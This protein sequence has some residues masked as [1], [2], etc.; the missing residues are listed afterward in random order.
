MYVHA[1]CVID[2]ASPEHHRE[3]LLNV[4]LRLTRS[5]SVQ[6]SVEIRLWN[7]LVE[8]AVESM[9]ENTISNLQSQHTMK[10]YNF[11]RILL[12]I[13]ASEGL[14]FRSSKTRNS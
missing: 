1:R 9:Q 4:R 5:T 11:I 8:K 6:R 13:Q 12:E 3:A 7:P 14:G 2:G 10:R